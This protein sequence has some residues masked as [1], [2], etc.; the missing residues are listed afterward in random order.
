MVIEN[1]LDIE[2][3]T[4]SQVDPTSARTDTTDTYSYGLE[5]NGALNLDGT[6]F[7]WADS[8]THKDGK[9][10]FAGNNSTFDITN[11]STSTI[12][13]LSLRK[14]DATVN[15]SSDIY[16]ER[17]E[18][19]Y[20]IFDI[21]SNTLQVDVLDLNPGDSVGTGSNGEFLLDA[22]NM[23]KMAGNQSDGGLSLKVAK[24]VYN[25]YSEFNTE[26][27]E[28]N[29]ANWLWFPIGTGAN[30]TTRYTP[31]VCYLIDNGT[32]DG[33]EYISLRV[34]DKILQ[35]TNLSSADDILSYFWNVDYEGYN[36]GEE[37]TVSWIFQYDESDIDS[38]DETT[39]VPGKVLDEGTYERSTDA[40]TID[41]DD[42]RAG[43]NT[44]STGNFLGDNP[45]N[46]ILFNNSTPDA[47]EDVD[48]TLDLKIF[49][50]SSV[51]SGWSTAI[52][53]TGF[54][55]E[56]ANYTA[57]G[58]DRFDGAP[59]I[60]YSRAENGT[61]WDWEDTDHWSTDTVYKHIGEI[62]G[63]V[64]GEGDIVVIGSEFVDV[65]TGGTYSK[66]GDGR[67]QVK[68]TST[69]GDVDVAE[70]IFDSQDGGSA[71]YTNEMSRIR[72][73]NG[74]TLTASIISGK[75]ELVQ[76]VGPNAGNF[77]TI[78]ADVG[79]FVDDPDNGW[80]FWI[81]AAG[82]T[83]VS[84]YSKY[85]VFRTFGGTN[86]N[87]QFGIDVE[88]EYGVV[89]NNTTLQ[90]ANNLTINNQLLVG[91]NDP[92]NVEF[93]E[94]GS[95]KTL[96]TGSILFDDIGSNTLTVENSGSDTHTL[97]VNGD[98]TF[99]GGTTFDL[100]SDAGS[101]VELELSTEGV[102]AL[103][104]SAGVIPDLYRIIM[105][106]GEDTTSS[107]TFNS[108]F[109]LPS[110]DDISLQPV[111]I[112]NGLLILNDSLIDITLTSEATGDFYLPNTYNAEASSGSGGLVISNGTVNLEGDD[113]GI[114]L[115]GLIR[116]NGGTL[117]LNDSINN[118]NNFIEY[119]SSGNAEIEVSDGSLI[120][121]SQL[122][123]SLSTSNGVLTYTQTGGSAMFGKN[124]APETTRGVFEVA[125]GNSN[126]TL[127]GGDFTIVRQNG[128]NPSIAA[129]YLQP[130][131]YDVSGSTITI[132]NTYTPT[133]QDEIGINS[134]IA[135]NN[136]VINGENEP[137]A[138]LYSN[139]LTVDGNLT[140][141]DSA[142]SL[143]TLDAD[144][145]TLTIN[146][147]FINN[148]NYIP[149]GNTTIF[150]GDID[151][152]ISG[153]GTLNF[154]NLTKTNSEILT[155]EKDITIENALDIDN[156]T[157]HTDT[158]AAYTEGNVT[159]DALH[160]STSGYGIV[161]SG[162]S[163]Q[164][165]LRSS[166]GTSTFGIIT[167][168]NTEGV[169]TPD[170]N[171]YFFT[172][173][174]NL[175]L[176]NGVLDIGN[177]LLTIDTY[178]EIEEVNTF[179]VTNMIQTNSSF[180]DYGVQKNFPAISSS[181]TFTFPVGES[182]YTPLTL[183]ISSSSAG[184]I[185]IRP[186][187]EI[188]P[189]ILE[190]DESTLSEGADPNIVDEDNALQY[191]WILRAS[192]LTGFSATATFLYDDEDIAVTSPY[193]VANY[194]PARL[195]SAGT[196]WDKAYSQADF[197]ENNNEINFVLSNADDDGI[198]GEYTAGVGVDDSDAVIYGAIPDE[199]PE[200]ETDQ[201][202]G[203]DYDDSGSWSSSIPSSGP[204]GAIVTVKSGDVL[205]LNNSGVRLLKTIIEEG[206]VLEIDGTNNH[207]L[208]TVEGTGTIKIVSNTSSASL[209]AG[210]YG[211][212]FSCSNGSLIYDGT[213]SY[214]V[215]GGINALE[216]LTITGSGTR[217]MAN[218]DINICNDWDISGSV[219]VNNI[220]NRNINVENDLNISDSGELKT[221][222]SSIN[223]QGDITLSSNGK[224]TGSQGNVFTFDG[225]TDQNIT[226]NFSGYAN[227]EFYG[228]TLNNSVGKIYLNDGD[229]IEVDRTLTFSNGILEMGESGL[230][231]LDTL[232][233]YTGSSS[234]SFADGYFGV[235]S[236]NTAFTF[237]VGDSASY[238]PISISSPTKGYWETMFRMQDPTTN[239]AID[240]LD[241]DPDLLSSYPD[242]EIPGLE[243][244]ELTGPSPGSAIVEIGWNE[245]SEI[246]DYTKIFEMQW[247][248]TDHWDAISNSPVGSNTSGTITSSGSVSF[249]TKFFTIGL[250]S[251]EIL[252]VDLLS[253]TGS[254]VDEIIE[255]NWQTS[256]EE[257]T[258][259]FEV[260]KSINGTEFYSIGNVTAVGN[261]TTINSYSFDDTDPAGGSNYY[262][263]KI[264]DKDGNY[265]Y[266]NVI[267]VNFEVNG[268]HRILVHPN[269]VE[270]H[271]VNLTLWGYKYEKEIHIKIIDMLGKIVFTSVIEDNTQQILQTELHLPDY[272][273]TG[274]Y[275]VIV[276]G[277]S[278]PKSQKILVK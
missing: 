157:F 37:A 109:T 234:S 135:I 274:I 25:G 133:G 92:G 130:D 232:G 77:G 223:L 140:I 243:Y 205:T 80:F 8:I 14:Q 266:S 170:G 54:T 244:Y 136:L 35:T 5:L 202:G 3:G 167:I 169:S 46:I 162:T 44:D 248:S 173:T 143:G 45:G 228:L 204:L 179:S 220:N 261:S 237:P 131:N 158:Y 121:G 68:I 254:V 278:T 192:G 163:A 159:N 62:A 95:N 55:L 10:Y 152:S 94:V 58:P 180:T 20:G 23:I 201:S 193:T 222:S 105:N 230:I 93:I 42:L 229:T 65:L 249:S 198:S 142:S 134:S 206:A 28:Y 120:V 239:A 63:T 13:N 175:R 15:L 104:D 260:E 1:Q 256:T 168:N 31:A 101:N 99:M 155:L 252:P 247:N 112:V 153:T 85:P 277:S 61:W 26:N 76:D 151:Q 235:E 116:I 184:S 145:L 236:L 79:D 149:N 272:L 4:L 88:A 30:S 128:S 82:T 66:S 102:H 18:F 186:A 176:E 74:I 271:M 217:T 209:P 59:T 233:T 185:T 203:G 6:L 171:G 148:G 91:S 240:N 250:G 19:K 87:F 2:S 178:G 166:I 268:E 33:D 210:Y 113:T 253:F 238:N 107:F 89:D 138:M 73:R 123:R 263:L 51:N 211:D 199:V 124:A 262:R 225:S 97:K 48:A 41:P 127:T 224:Y 71:L 160:T 122:R 259:S 98:I 132:G 11:T 188:H 241:P 219:V 273:P 24:T 56:K 267:T 52:P 75:G 258:E 12:G 100:T 183:D 72:V 7:E 269:P 147:D 78:T 103:Y 242:F 21:S 83:V 195:L 22:N 129:L 182:K 110:P 181:T 275:Q 40:D 156:G 57:G 196:T 191:H 187:D 16:V 38:G 197:D 137:T 227:S 36:S 164:K 177:S 255:L 146:G 117:S 49:D 141:V 47:I 150:S 264:L 64:P 246:E 43:G 39:Y 32:T 96:E 172:I 69:H 245:Y 106:K 70:I 231:V 215:L 218:N 90:I 50:G 114:I 108:S 154:Y 270:N 119:T 190:D 216:N 194:I 67:H 257:N 226:G 115:D 17:L 60:Y 34:A 221:G 118:G 86:R 207:R 165:M 213:G 144:G 214:D 208:G 126:F 111:E 161:F 189:S 84:D 29:N 251:V 27:E 139:A 125:N 212:F 265:E 276:N 200:Y 9:V 81:L 174:D 53:G